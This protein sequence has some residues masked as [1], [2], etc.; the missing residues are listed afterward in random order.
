MFRDGG[1][2]STGCEQLAV[3]G[4]E[5]VDSVVLYIPAEALDQRPWG[6]FH[7]RILLDYRCVP[8]VLCEP[9]VNESENTLN[10]YWEVNAKSLSCHFELVRSVPVCLKNSENWRLERKNEGEY[11][12]S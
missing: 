2:T 6:P 12:E 8:P 10:T 5:A 11:H 4:S 1:L 3:S 7:P 9:V